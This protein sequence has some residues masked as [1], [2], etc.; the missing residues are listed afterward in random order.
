MGNDTIDL[1]GRD[2]AD[3]LVRLYNASRPQGMGMLSH[4]IKHHSMSHTEAKK[5]LDS[6]STYFGYIHG[7][8]LKVDLSGDTL[9]P[10]LYDRDNGPGAAAAAIN[11]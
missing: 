4:D 1:R 10:R 8:V 11:G 9:D 5:M 3:V 6:G 7:R 2:K